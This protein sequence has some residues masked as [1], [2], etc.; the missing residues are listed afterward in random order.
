MAHHGQQ[1]AKCRT[2]DEHR[3]QLR[4]GSNL[5]GGSR[6]RRMFKPFP[7]RRK[8]EGDMMCRALGEEASSCGKEL[9]LLI[10]IYNTCTA[11]CREKL[12]H[13]VCVHVDVLMSLT[14]GVHTHLCQ[15]F[16]I[17]IQV[18]LRVQ[19]LV[20]LVWVLEARLHVVL[21]LHM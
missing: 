12:W 14:R 21:V 13:T 16:D 20:R 8:C 7:K 18:Q 2:V 6:N 5:G 10:F 19:E 4:G 11:N 1:R 15:R 17:L 3:V 9:G